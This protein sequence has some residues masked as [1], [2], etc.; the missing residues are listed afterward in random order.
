MSSITIGE[1]F[2]GRRHTTQLGLALEAAGIAWIAARSPQ[3]KGRIERL[4]G[5]LQDRLR[6]ELRLAR[7]ATL[8]EANHVLADYLPRHNARFAVPAGDPAAAW[9]DLPT[10]RSPEAIFCFRHARHLARD[11][12]FT[13][14]GQSLMVVG[15]ERPRASRVTVQQHLDGTLWLEHGD[16]LL[17][18]A[19][20]PERPVVLR[21]ASSN[22]S[23]STPI[24][25][26]NHDP[27]HPWRRYPA[28]NP[29]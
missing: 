17:T 5:T 13:L 29:R 8:E 1:Q 19:A 22:R 23:T 15:G 27:Y 20:A 25:T 2:G 10:D 4:W 3:A 28:V 9:R 7:A 21:A 18:V 14:F 11:G 26:G 12:T 6:S 24:P 16:Q